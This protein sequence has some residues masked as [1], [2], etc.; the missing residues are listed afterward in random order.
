MNVVLIGYGTIASALM[1][2]LLS[3]FEGEIKC[4]KVI[5]PYGVKKLS[6]DFDCP[7]VWVTTSVTKENL[8]YLLS[9]LDSDSFFNKL[10]C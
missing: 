8:D 7:V 2:N 6:A 3:E 9:E 10:V 5:D 1:P 4:L